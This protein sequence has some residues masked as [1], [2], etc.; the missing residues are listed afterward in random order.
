MEIKGDLTGFAVICCD[1]GHF[2]P[3]MEQNFYYLPDLTPVA[4]SNNDGN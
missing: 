1:T 3:S 4:R 2:F